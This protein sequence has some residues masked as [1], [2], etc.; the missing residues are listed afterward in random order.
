MATNPPASSFDY[1][2]SAASTTGGD[3]DLFVSLL[4]GRQP[5]SDDYDLASQKKGADFI[6]VGSSSLIWAQKGWETKYGVAVVV[7]VRTKA[8]MNYTLVMSKVFSSSTSSP[9]KNMKFVRVGDVPVTGK[10]GA[11]SGTRSS[12]ND[13][14]YMM[15]NW[16]H[17]D[18]SVT[19]KM[20]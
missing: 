14:I 18:F 8:A 7:G 13:F 9:E 20:D 4:D 1:H 17:K 10:L 2:I 6:E 5:S 12:N 3:P 19:L 16:E 11:V 15:Q